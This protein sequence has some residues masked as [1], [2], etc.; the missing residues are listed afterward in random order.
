MVNTSL[1]SDDIA[2]LGV[3]VSEPS[4][5]SGGFLL[6]YAR[7]LDQDGHGKLGQNI[8]GFVAEKLAVYIEAEKKKMLLA[9][10]IRVCFVFWEWLEFSSHLFNCFPN[11]T[12][13]VAFEKLCNQLKTVNETRKSKSKSSKNRF[14]LGCSPVPRT[15]F[16]SFGRLFFSTSAKL[17]TS[18]SGSTACVGLFLKKEIEEE[19]GTLYSA[20]IGDSRSILCSLASRNSATSFACGGPASPPLEVTQLTRDHKPELHNERNRIIKAGGRVAI[21]AKG[22][23]YR[24]FQVQDA[25]TVSLEFHSPATDFFSDLVYLFV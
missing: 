11:E 1:S 24:V 18:E 25:S 4:N 23:P 19:L 22:H 3:M 2:I 12:L 14:H 9:S 5:H 16:S 10:P 20:N 8:S 13:R 17:D 21:M 6:I 15:S 7:T